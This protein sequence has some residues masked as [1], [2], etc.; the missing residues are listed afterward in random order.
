MGTISTPKS[1]SLTKTPLGSLFILYLASLAVVL[2]FTIFSD[3]SLPLITGGFLL[4]AYTTLVLTTFV[5]SQLWKD[6]LNPLSLLIFVGFIRFSIPGLLMLL[7]IEPNIAI[8]QL[9]GL[10]RD[11]WFLGHIL[12][13]MG[14]LG[15]VIGWFIPVNILK[16]VL[17]RTMAGTK[18]NLSKSV[19]HVAILGMLFGL[20]SLFMFMGSNT[21]IGEAILTGS[22]RRTEIREGTGIYFYLSLVLIAGSVVSSSYL[23]IKGRPWWMVL[24]PTIVAGISFW[25]LGGRARSL[26]SLIAG[27][28]L[29][30]YRQ[31]NRKLSIKVIGIWAFLI[32]ALAITLFAGQL[33]RGGFGLA[34]MIEALRIQAL[35][36]YVQ[37]AVWVDLGQ[38]HPLAAAVSI[39]EGVLGGRTFWALLWPLS[40]VLNLPGK[41]SGVFIV[42]ELV[43][44]G[45]RKWGFHSSLIGDAYMNFGLIGVFAV[46]IIFG[47][48][49]KSLYWE[50]RRGTVNIALYV[51]AATYALRVFYESIDKWGETLVILTFAITIIKLGRILSRTALAVYESPSPH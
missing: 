10:D 20:L 44:F 4:L 5:T 39:G 3:I 29:L 45:E 30:W 27:L 32:S 48:I 8:F 36:E 34:G 40:E 49:L 43:G 17:C 25:F 1:L 19:Y 23:A 11:V 15:V 41:S 22:F 26:T 50:F 2:G 16:V 47:T 6:W 12:A 7:G 38:L 33:Y 21:S 28:L 42:Q 18:R 24:L 13:L 14:L 51:L 37:W 46:T 35:F 31:S 9:M